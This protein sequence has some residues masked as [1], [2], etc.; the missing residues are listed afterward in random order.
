MLR[1]Q[2]QQAGYK[3]TDLPEASE[4]KVLATKQS[5]FNKPFFWAPYDSSVWTWADKANLAV[6]FILEGAD[7]RCKAAEIFEGPNEGQILH[8]VQQDLIAKGVHILPDGWKAIADAFRDK[9]GKVEDFEAVENLAFSIGLQF[10]NANSTLVQ[11]FVGFKAQ[12]YDLFNMILAKDK[13]R[14]LQAMYIL[15]TD[16]EAVGLCAGMQKLLMDLLNAREARLLLKMNSDAYAAKMGMHPYR[17]KKLYEQTSMVSDLFAKQLIHFF[18]RLEVD[19][20]TSRAI[21]KSEIFKNATMLFL[22]EAT[23]VA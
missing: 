20:K 16:D 15:V 21:S 11:Q 5:L 8:K 1:D 10:E 17:A 9:E 18:N 2:L 12:I 23:K 14:T 6:P 7:G 22:E 3:L 4:L 19:L 13:R